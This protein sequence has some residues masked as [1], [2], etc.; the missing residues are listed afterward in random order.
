VFGMPGT[1]MPETRSVAS[2]VPVAGASMCAM[3][4][5]SDTLTT[6]SWTHSAEASGFA[7]CDPAGAAAAVRHKKAWANEY[8]RIALTGAVTLDCGCE[9]SLA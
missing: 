6:A 3:M 4:P 2:A 8:F 9:E 1:T 7:A 5:A